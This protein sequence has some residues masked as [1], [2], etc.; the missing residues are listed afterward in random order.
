MCCRS[1]GGRLAIG[2][3]RYYVPNLQPMIGCWPGIVLAILGF[4]A[5]AF[6]LSGF[7]RR[8]DDASSMPD[9]AQ[10]PI[11]PDPEPVP[12]PD[13]EPAPQSKIEPA[14]LTAATAAASPAAPSATIE[15]P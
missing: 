12:E 6:W 9:D 4:L 10:A 7:S 2:A 3:I 14:V 5:L 8:S 13:Q 1:S 15:D 11:E